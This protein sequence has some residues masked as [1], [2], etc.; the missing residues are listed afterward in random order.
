MPDIFL[1]YI[2][3][4]SPDLSLFINPCRVIHDVTKVIFNKLS[5]SN[6]NLNT[7]LL[8]ENLH[9]FNKELNHALS[10]KGIT[11]RELSILL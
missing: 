11:I 5:I 1:S 8:D 2:L 4:I 3:K 9:E 7:F 6:M 10:S